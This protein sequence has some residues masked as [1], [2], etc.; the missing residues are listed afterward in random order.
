LDNTHNAVT[1]SYAPADGQ[2]IAR[3]MLSWFKDQ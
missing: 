1:D 2:K 3:N